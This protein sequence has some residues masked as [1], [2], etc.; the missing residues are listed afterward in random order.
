MARYSAFLACRISSLAPLP[1]ASS[2]LTSFCTRLT[3]M[4][5][6]DVPAVM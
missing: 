6:S 3:R 1:N 2:M 5:V 4:G